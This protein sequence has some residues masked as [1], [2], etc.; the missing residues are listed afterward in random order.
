VLLY[1]TA[2]AAYGQVKADYLFTPGAAVV[3]LKDT[4]A[5]WTAGAG[6]E[7]RWRATGAPSSNISTSISARTK[8]LPR[9]PALTS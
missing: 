6:I 9:W 4:K 1:G 5:G 2:G 8:S 7:A 3:S